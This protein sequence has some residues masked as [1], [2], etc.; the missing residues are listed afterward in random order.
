MKNKTTEALRGISTKI[1]SSNGTASVVV[2]TKHD[3]DE[4]FQSPLDQLQN[5][6]EV[7][8]KDYSQKSA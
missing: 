5:L 6:F 3:L 2:K 4:H 1:T 7:F 8:G